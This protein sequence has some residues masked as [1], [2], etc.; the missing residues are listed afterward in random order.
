MKTLTKNFVLIT[1]ALVMNACGTPKLIPNDSIARN[2]ATFNFTPP[3]QVSPGAVNMSIAI[4]KPV[5]ISKDAEY[6]SSP[7]PEMATSM[8]NDFEEI[9]TTKGFT[10]RGPFESRDA[11][12]YTE[13]KN[14]SFIIQIE[15]D[16]RLVSDSYTV[17]HSNFNALGLLVASESFTNDSYTTKGNITLGGNLILTAL[18]SQYGEKIWKKQIALNN[19]NFSYVGNRLYSFRPSIADQLAKDNKFYNAFIA[20]LEK[21]YAYSLNLVWSQLDPAEM[22]IVAN[23]AKEA[24]ARNN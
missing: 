20:E 10:V 23:Q 3:S 5:F 15:I 22:K 24:D 18:S 8:G 9:L 11:M 13:K 19:S 14:S 4:V 7:F 21:F 6:L 16:L 1:F 12:V 2:L 17:T